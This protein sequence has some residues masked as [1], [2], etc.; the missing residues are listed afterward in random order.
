M[1]P[2]HKPESDLVTSHIYCESHPIT[3]KKPSGKVGQHLGFTTSTETSTE[4][5]VGRDLLKQLL[6]PLHR[7]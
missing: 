5:K 1:E 3:Q 6:A 2:I 7:N 4:T